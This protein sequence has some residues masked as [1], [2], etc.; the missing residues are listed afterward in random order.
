MPTGDNDGKKDIVVN[1]IL[2]KVIWY[3]NTG[4]LFNLEGPYNVKA[5]WNDK[6]TPKPVWN[7]WEPGKTDLVTQWRTTPY[8]IDWNRDGLTDLIMLD[9]EGYLSLYERFQRNGELWLKPGKHIFYL[10]DN[11]NNKSKTKHSLSDAKPLQLTSGIA[12]KSGRRKLCLVD[13]NKDGRIDLMVNSTNACYYENVQQNGDTVYFENKGDISQVKLA[14]HDTSPTP[15]DW[16]KDGIPDL[17]LGA[18]D[19]HFYLLKNNSQ[20]K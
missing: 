7:W 2:G 13:W 16:D 6:P 20:T 14:G 18:E 1:T 17:L 8:A 15:V 4:D 5:D 9:H 3:K 12:G 19:G 11:P 10:L